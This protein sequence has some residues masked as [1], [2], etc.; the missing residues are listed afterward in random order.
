MFLTVPDW[1]NIIERM[2]FGIL[3]VSYEVH[4]INQP[5]YL[6]N[7]LT[8]LILYQVVVHLLLLPVCVPFLLVNC[9]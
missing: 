7:L 3:P 2:Q 1:L 6:R 4:Q 8:I 5:F 9:T